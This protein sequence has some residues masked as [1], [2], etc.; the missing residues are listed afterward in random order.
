MGNK[1]AV[2][3][4]ILGTGGA[5]VVNSLISS[6]SAWE[7]SGQIMSTVLVSP[8]EGLPTQAGLDHAPAG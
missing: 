2:W 8:E 6:G 4:L 1:L 3:M 7:V 5:G